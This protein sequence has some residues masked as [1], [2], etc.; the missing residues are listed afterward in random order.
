MGWFSEWLR[1]RP[2]RKCRHGKR[3]RIVRPALAE[4]ETR[5]V[6]AVVAQNFINHG[7]PVLGSPQVELVYLGSAWSS[8]SS[9]ETQVNNFASSLV[10]S[11]FMDVLS[12]Y[13]VG[14]G[15]VAGSVVLPVAL[16]STVSPQ[17]IQNTLAQDVANGT[18]PQPG[19]NTLLFVLTPPNVGVRD[20]PFAQVNFLGYHS[21]LSDSQGAYAVVP[22]PGGSNPQAAGLTAFQSLT[23]TFSHEL[24]EA[25]TDPFVNAQGNPSGWDDYTFDPTGNVFQGEIGD[26]AESAPAVFLN[27]YAVTQLWSNQADAVVAPAGATTAPGASSLTVTARDVPAAIANQPFTATVASI[28]DTNAN[29]SAAGLTATVNWGDNSGTDTT[30]RVTTDAN[31]NLVVQDT[32]T[33]TAAGHYTVT[34]T[35]TDG[36][37]TA[38][39]TST[40]TVTAPASLTVKANNLTAQ[41]GQA[42]S[43]PVATVS[44]PGADASKLTATIDWGDQTTPD[45]VAV[46]TD[47]NGNLI[48]QGTHTYAAA[49]SFTVTVTV[50][51]GGGTAS[52]TSTATVATA[53]TTP[54][55]TIAVTGQNVTAETGQPFLATVATVT[56]PGASAFDLVA[57][58]DWGDGS[59]PSLVRLSGPDAQG[60]FNVLGFHRYDA[61]G[62]Y[63]IAVTV[64]DRETG[65]RATAT[66]TANVADSGAL[67]VTSDRIDATAGTSFTGTVAAV[68]DPGAS[69]A[70]LTATVNWGDGTT[71][72][73]VAVTTDA[74]GNLVVQGTHTYAQVGNYPVTVTVTDKST[75]DRAQSF[76][77][78]DVDPAPTPPS[79]RVKAVDL[80]AT[81]GQSFTDGIAAVFVPGASASDLKVTV[82]WGDGSTTDS[83]AQVVPFGI[84]GLFVIV[85]THSYAT[86][87]QFTITVTVT[88]TADGSMGT[89]TAT[90]VVAAAPTTPAATTAPTTTITPTT[91]T[92]P[93]TDTTPTTPPTDV[94][95]P[96]TTTTTPTPSPLHRGV[97]HHPPRHASRRRA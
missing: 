81:A 4:L 67:S 95:P 39:D 9:L 48:V 56:D 94:T 19:P 49:G 83:S 18:L 36:T 76:S 13:G 93:P 59:W 1:Q 43:G 26:I 20:N 45:T 64:L 51:D 35:V 11:F 15:T 69:A 50:K 71:D 27:N 63:T 3:L 53:T 75:G 82:N 72:R 96:A 80:K 62:T 52:D 89:S 73:N 37:T 42:F 91:P 32:H 40:A 84:G 54:T 31:G 70:N 74:N 58:I 6:P 30:A 88:D 57:R 46:T 87:G 77:V 86:A 25:V 2:G 55:G 8:D 92:T 5:V 41:P 12:Q 61:K 21:S 85:G 10:G 17:Q 78:A 66:A 7:G 23:D 97:R 24:A 33:Y 22:Y 38:S 34:V 16:G 65:D 68:S 44:D 29:A 60:N 28:T 90:A 14:H 47:A 79:V